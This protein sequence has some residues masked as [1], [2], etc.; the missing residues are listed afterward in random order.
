MCDPPPSIAG[1]WF[2]SN[3]IKSTSYGDA[4]GSGLY[5]DYNGD[6]EK[7]E[8]VSVHVRS[9]DFTSNSAVSSSASA[10][11]GG[12]SVTGVPPSL[13]IL[14][15]SF[16]ANTVDGA[17]AG[18]G[19]GAFLS[20]L[21]TQSKTVGTS[22]E[23][24]VVHFAHIRFDANTAKASAGTARGGGLCVADPRR[25]LTVDSCEFEGNRV[26]VENRLLCRGSDDTKRMPPLRLRDSRF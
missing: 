22:G 4:F 5:L 10:R 9:T 20:S 11:G 18:D 17:A 19:G 12:A 16:R 8:N 13:R 26:T 25:F 2:D 21:Q 1:C 23:A 6:V 24:Q 15:C 3:A 14:N 7:V